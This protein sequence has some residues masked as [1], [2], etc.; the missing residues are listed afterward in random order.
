DVRGK[1]KGKALALAMVE[2]EKEE[3]GAGEEFSLLT[4]WTPKLLVQ[5][6]PK[7]ID[8]MENEGLEGGQVILVGNKA[9]ITLASC[10]KWKQVGVGQ[11]VQKKKPPANAMAL[12]Q[13]VMMVEAA[14]VLLAARG[15]LMAYYQLE[16]GK[17][18]K[19]S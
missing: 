1:G 7:P 3:K 16:R 18:A 13:R 4:E 8:V 5:L 2:E 6:L 15:L 17:K 10:K 11:R 14:K 19:A 12:A 9:A